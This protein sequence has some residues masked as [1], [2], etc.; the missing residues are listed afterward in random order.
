MSGLAALSRVSIRADIPLLRL[1]GRVARTRGGVVRQRGGGGRGDGV[2]SFRT[3]QHSQRAE[4]NVDQLAPRAVQ[5]ERHVVAE[6]QVGD[7]DRQR[8]GAAAESGRSPAKI[9]CR[10]YSAAMT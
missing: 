5:A 8:V 9:R 7:V 10:A 2:A 3:A 1:F 4:R 6:G